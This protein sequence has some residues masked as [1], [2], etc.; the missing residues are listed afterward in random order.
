MLVFQVP[1]ETLKVI[2]SKVFQS[3]QEGLCCG[4]LLKSENIVNLKDS[5][6]TVVIACLLLSSGPVIIEAQPP[7]PFLKMGTTTGQPEG[8]TGFSA[9]QRIVVNAELSC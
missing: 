3:V 1:L 7:V 8:Q 2:F 5:Y 4:F 6:V 9:L